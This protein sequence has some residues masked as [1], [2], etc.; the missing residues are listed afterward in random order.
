M[1]MTPRLEDPRAAQEQ[2]EAEATF[3]RDHYR[4]LLAAYP[5]QFVAVAADTGEVVAAS[6]DVTHL[7]RLLDARRL[8]PEQVWVR[9]LTADARRLM[10]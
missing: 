10:H 9:F 2:A 5:D 6:P 8:R 4:E 3:W 7:K 1:A